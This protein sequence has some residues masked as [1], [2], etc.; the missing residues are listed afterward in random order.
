L[1]DSE[2][3]GLSSA[4]ETV[5]TF[6]ASV[7]RRSE[8]EFYLR[9]FR[10]LP[11]ESFALVMVRHAALHSVPGSFVEQLRFLA[12][13]GLVAPIVLGAWSPQGADTAAADLADDLGRRELDTVRYDLER[14]DLAEV[15][16]LALKNRTIPLVC[17]READPFE[18]IGQLAHRLQTR[19]L[20][21]LRREG[22]LGPHGVP[23]IEVAPGHELPVHSGGISVVNLRADRD[24][25]VA[26]GHLTP[27]DSKLLA[28]IQ[29]LLEHTASAS[30]TLSVTSPLSLL[31]ELFTVKGAGTLVKLGS[32]I[33]RLGSYA[34]LDRARLTNLLES[35][36]KRNL[37][38]T[39]FE[40]APEAIYLEEHYRGAALVQPG[41]RG[42]FLTKFAVDPV[43]RGEGIGQDLWRA[44]YR[45]TPRLYWR[46]RPDNAILGWYKS[47]CD[48]FMH[49]GEWAVFWRGYPP[50]E[51]AEVVSDAV[52]R[53]MDFEG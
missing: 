12:D 28:C 37:K 44:M 46:S 7:G 11:K 22:G 9:L 13:L 35:S 38:T 52:N 42:A 34:Q 23:A 21:V 33:Q 43:A 15:L 26:S 14:P 25:L 4:A 29:T 20:V 10:Q 49:H 48:G 1:S 18:R 24:A 5:L 53:P 6:L 39:F 40:T 2:V 51:L 17:S 19:K 8:A 47:V 32:S 3:H 31:N 36:F 16:A 50:Q 30:T 27:R 41:V 45:D